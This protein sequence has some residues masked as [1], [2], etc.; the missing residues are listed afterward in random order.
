VRTIGKRNGKTRQFGLLQT[1]AT[2]PCN[3]P[4]KAAVNRKS[5]HRVWSSLKDLLKCCS[6]F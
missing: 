2:R 1:S 4:I 5:E 3:H 6:A